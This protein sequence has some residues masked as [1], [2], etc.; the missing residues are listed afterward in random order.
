MI[1][2]TKLFASLS[3]SGLAISIGIVGTAATASATTDPIYGWT[4]R[5]QVGA[6][7]MIGAP[8]A[9]M[10]DLTLSLLED[11]AVGG[12]FLEG[13][14]TAGV[15]AIA[16]QTA[17]YREVKTTPQKLLISTDQEGGNVTVLRGPG[18]TLMPSA[19]AQ[20]FTTTIGREAHTWGLELRAAGVNVNLAPVA[21]LVDRDMNAKDNPPTGYWDRQ[22]GRTPAEIQAKAGA[23]ARG[24]QR[25]EV[26]PTIK[27]FP[28]LG[29]VNGNTDI[30]TGVTDNVTTPD[31]AS[32]RLF[33]QMAIRLQNYDPKPWVMMGTAV[34]DKID[35]HNPAAFSAKAVQLVRDAGFYGVIITDDLSNAAQVTVYPPAERAI[36]ALEAG[37]DIVLYSAK[38]DDV[39]EAMDAVF[40]KA[41]LVPEFRTKVED[42]ARRVAWAASTLPED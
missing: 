20:S 11:Y 10:S 5:Q 7:F 6:V 17:K 14:S 26:I 21:D 24:M 12:V 38:I 18:F 19:L 36:R 42:A 1:S 34:Y 2:K 25:A 41:E 31:D 29:R 8:V 15:E 4:L 27:H 40:R 16:E 23:F 39:A 28:G 13:R 32:V 9:E 30:A 37:V 3:A 33:N 35:S 22:Y